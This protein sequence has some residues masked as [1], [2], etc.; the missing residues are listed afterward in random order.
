MTGEVQQSSHGIKCVGEMW[1][2][3]VIAYIFGVLRPL[4]RSFSPTQFWL[5]ILKI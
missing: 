2:F 1:L 5:E 4:D 3:H